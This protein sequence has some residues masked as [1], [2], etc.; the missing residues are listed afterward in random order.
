MDT[1]L[2]IIFRTL[3]I[4]FTV[5]ILMRI[6]GKRE[7]GQISTFDFVVAVIIAELAALPMEQDHKP[8]WEGLLPIFVVVASEMVLA[9]IALKSLTFRYLMDGRPSIVIQNGRIDD[10]E[11]AKNRYNINDLLAQLREK[12][13]ANIND[14]EFAILE[15]SGKLS[16]IFKSQKRPVTPEDLG[17][18]T[19]YEG[20]SVPLIIEGQV[21]TENLDRVNL[22][23]EWLMEEIKSKG[24]QNI[25]EVFYASLDSVGKLFVSKKIT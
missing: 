3:I 22:N 25:K 6:M 2:R 5:L 10:K 23:R 8:L 15:S 4:Y 12:G 21:I 9:Y 7:I 13:V 1:A 20:L 17:I 18:S 11:M 24:Y 19:L 14:V 16:I